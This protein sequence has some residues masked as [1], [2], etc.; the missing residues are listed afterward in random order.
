MDP[1]WGKQAH[2]GLRLCLEVGKRRREGGKEE[3]RT[4]QDKGCLGVQGGG[5]MGPLCGPW[6]HGQAFISLG[7]AGQR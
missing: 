1:W 6:C 2:W 7:Q 5:G 3:G 4:S